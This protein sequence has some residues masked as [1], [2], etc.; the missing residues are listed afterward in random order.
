MMLDCDAGTAPSHGIHLEADEGFT[1]SRHPMVSTTT[2]I[3]KTAGPVLEFNPYGISVKLHSNLSKA[4]ISVVVLF[5]L[6][7]LISVKLSSA[8]KSESATN[9]QPVRN[10]NW[11]RS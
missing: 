2:S 8:W 9:A 4:G 3:H 11:P 1:Q 6:G 7:S 10:F 5:W